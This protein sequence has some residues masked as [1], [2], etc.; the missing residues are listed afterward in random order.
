[1][2]RFHALRLGVSYY[3]VD[4]KSPITFTG[5]INNKKA[6]PTPPFYS[7]AADKVKVRDYVAN[8]IG[9]DYLIK[10]IGVYKNAHSIDLSQLPNEFIVKANHGSGW[11]LR[12]LDKTNLNW[13]KAAKTLQRWLNMNAYYLS[14]ES[15][16]RS[17][18]PKLIIEEVIAQNPKDYKI[19]CANGTPRIIQVDSNRFSNHTRDFFSVDWDPLDFQ[20]IYPSSKNEIKV[21]TNLNLMLQLATELS[22][23]FEFVRV[24]LY[25]VEGKIYFGELTFF[26][27]GG[28]SFFRTSEEDRRFFEVLFHA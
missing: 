2:R 22:S 7:I 27:E 14:R 1:M 4:Y 3:P 18:Q 8:K 26:P 5:Y 24:D 10:A 23:D 6:A 25:N 16:Y 13:A 11:N 28:N 17:I 12:C 20:L 21:P 19:Y 9:R 15:H